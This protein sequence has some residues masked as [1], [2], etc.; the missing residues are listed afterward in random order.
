[1]PPNASLVTDGAARF[2]GHPYTLERAP[3][4][5]AAPFESGV[6]A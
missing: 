5:Q 6:T 4:R 2:K 1:M 3:K